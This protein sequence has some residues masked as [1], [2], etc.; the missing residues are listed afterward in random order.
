MLELLKKEGKRK[1]TA[2]CFECNTEHDSERHDKVHK[3]RDIRVAAI[4]KVWQNSSNK[5][6]ICHSADK[7]QF[8]CHVI[9]II[10][11]WQQTTCWLVSV[12]FFVLWILMLTE[13]INFSLPSFVLF[14]KSK[15]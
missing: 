8:W 14:F 1:P 3:V 4:V 6:P 10:V 13:H 9:F 11:K 15:T 12:S 5:S 7:W 2:V